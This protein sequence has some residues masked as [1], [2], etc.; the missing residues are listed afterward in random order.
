MPGDAFSVPP[1]PI[2]R[3][4]IGR[5]KWCL[6]AMN[7]PHILVAMKKWAFGRLK[8]MATGQ[9]WNHEG[10]NPRTKEDYDRITLEL[11][12][13]PVILALLDNLGIMQAC[14]DIGVCDAVTEAIGRFVDIV[15]EH[16][17]YPD[18]VRYHI[19]PEFSEVFQREKY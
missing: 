7:R 18:D 13:D 6:A 16:E 11:E 10:C 2:H 17:D 19:K 12:T 15:P 14:D 5:W 8:I 1:V 9:S 4:F 3:G